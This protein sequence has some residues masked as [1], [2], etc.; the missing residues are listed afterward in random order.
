MNIQV[1]NREA[2]EHYRTDHSHIAISITDPNS[3]PAKF[4]NEND[5]LLDQLELQFYD[6]DRDTGQF[7]YSRF[8]FTEA[9]ASK[10]LHF[11][12][13]YENAVDTILVHC[14]AGIS[15]SSGIAGAL[16][17]IYNGDDQH[18]FSMYLPNILVYRTILEVYENEF[19][20]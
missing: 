12:V 3:K 11:V 16:S 5:S 8:T 9:N 13:K 17:L 7:P 2:F 14:E 6:L 20:G 19:T 4:V 10:I 18:F 15:R 1:F